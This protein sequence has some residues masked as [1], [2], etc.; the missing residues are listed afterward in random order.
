MKIRYVDFYKV[1]LYILV[2]FNLGFSD[3]L[4]EYIMQIQL[5]TIIV[6]VI[7]LCIYLIQPKK[8]IILK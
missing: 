4:K 6:A 5:V 7:L 8:I 2:F 3:F 1:V